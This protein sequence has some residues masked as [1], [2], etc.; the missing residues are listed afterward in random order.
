MFDRFGRLIR[1]RVDRPQPVSPPVTPA[2][3]AAGD[4]LLLRDGSDFVVEAAFECREVPAGAMSPWRLLQLDDGSLL[5]SQRDALWLY[6]PPDIL[7]P[8]SQPFRSLTG[9]GGGEGLLRR[10][11]AQQASPEPSQPVVYADERG[12]YRI[13]ATGAFS[14]VVTGAPS[15]PVW[16]ALSP[17]PA[18]NVYVRMA[19]GAE[20][21]LGI[22]T[23]PIALY[24]GGPLLTIDIKGMY[25]RG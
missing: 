4:V 3:L 19:D 23:G 9:Q 21:L 12:S 16:T 13:I 17:N 20:S 6:G 5:E 22:W 1:Q 24:R 15:G 25:S 10:F 11:E 2:T 18:E 8:G 14:A 7:V